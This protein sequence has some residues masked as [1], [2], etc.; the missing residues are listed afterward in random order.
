M[1]LYNQSILSAIDA[2][3]VVK[4]LHELAYEKAVETL[5]VQ[6][7]KTYYAAQA[8]KEQRFRRGR[9]AHDRTGRHRQG[10]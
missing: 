10:Q 1:P 3:K 5:T 9:K 4:Q 8:F 7:A 2:A 6:I